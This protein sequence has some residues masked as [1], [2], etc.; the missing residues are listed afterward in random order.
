MTP[1]QLKWTDKEWASH[2]S[3]DVRD[4]PAL[5]QWM[6][7]NYF[8]GI[9]RNSRTG[10]YYFCMTKL[11]VAP[12]GAHRVMPVVSSDKQFESSDMATKYANEEILPRMRFNPIYAKALGVPEGALQ[13]LHIENQKQK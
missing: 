11:D 10:N 2:L 9:A 13:M 3:W 4:I 5:R 8:P 6:Q 12:S 7:E 1:E